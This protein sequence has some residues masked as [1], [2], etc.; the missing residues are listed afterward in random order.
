MLDILEVFLNVYGWTYYRLDG[1]TPVENRQR[2]TELFNRSDRV[3]AFIMTTR[4]GGLGLNLIGAD[5]VIF[6][7]SDWNPAM[8]AQA[9]DRA[10]RIG[11]TKDVHIY[12]LITEYTVEETIFLKASQKR[13]MN[14]LT[15]EEGSFTLDYLKNIRMGD[16]LG[17]TAKRLAEDSKDIEDEEETIIDSSDTDKRRSRRLRSRGSNV[18]MTDQELEQALASLEDESDVQA[19]Q[20][21]AAEK[22]EAMAEF[23]DEKVEVN[24][25]TESKD[26]EE[27]G[28]ENSEKYNSQTQTA[29]SSRG[30]SRLSKPI[31]CSPSPSN[32]SSPVT[33]TR[34]SSPESEQREAMSDIAESIDPVVN[35]HMQCKENTWENV[36]RPVEQYA[37]SFVENVLPVIDKQQLVILDEVVKLHQEE[38]K[39]EE[40]ERIKAC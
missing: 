28:R 27:S 31:S 32:V 17:E 3:F 21:L 26:E 38:W 7:D 6:Y 39:L 20:L 35:N 23:D 4:A 30:R 25:I 12:R 18:V 37:L 13:E 22:A 2:M 29:R 14:K 8:D 1:S 16:I 15:I 36:L 10:H 19:T 34:E 24:L 9:Q 11:Q 33:N 40:L 5:T